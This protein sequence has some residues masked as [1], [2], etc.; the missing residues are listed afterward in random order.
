[1]SD[2]LVEQ[3]LVEERC[4]WRHFRIGVIV[5]SDKVVE[6]LKTD[7]ARCFVQAVSA[8]HHVAPDKVAE[9]VQVVSD[10]RHVAPERVI[11]EVGLKP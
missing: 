10:V 8:A 11:L 4:F 5:A 3:F 7:E 6:I 2:Y 9:I 1:M